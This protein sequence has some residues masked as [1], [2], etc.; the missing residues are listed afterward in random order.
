M[1][2]SD[3]K[4]LAVLRRDGGRADDLNGLIARSVSAGHVI[5]WTEQDNYSFNT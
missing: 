1:K 4:P 5:V 2:L 3:V